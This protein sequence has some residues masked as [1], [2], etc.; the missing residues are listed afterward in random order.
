MTART[1]MLARRTALALA[2][3]LATSTSAFAGWGG[4]KPAVKKV[5]GRG[6]RPAIEK[7]RAKAKAKGVLE[8]VTVVGESRSGKSVRALAVTR[9]GTQ[10]KVTAYNVHKTTR[11][12]RQT[13]TSL[14][15]IGQATAIASNKMRRERAPNA[16]TFSGVV[17]KGVT[18]KGSLKFTSQTDRSQRVFV[19]PATGA[20]TT[21]E[22]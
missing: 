10:R 12:A 14:L 17:F 11:V 6:A 9:V 3:L 18:P 4:A 16:G 2:V 19:D 22:K 15:T 8:Q 21:K 1:A 7:A 5:D 20:A 13:P